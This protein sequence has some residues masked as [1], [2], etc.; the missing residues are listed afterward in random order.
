MSNSARSKV[1]AVQLGMF[2]KC[3]ASPPSVIDFS[4]GFQLNLSSG[5][6]SSVF[7]VLAI[8]CSN[9]GRI[10]SLIDIGTS[11]ERVAQIV[12]AR[13][14]KYPTQSSSSSLSFWYCITLKS[15]GLEFSF[16]I[17]AYSGD[18]ET[19]TRSE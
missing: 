12:R 9:S 10:I 18:G 14:Y 17:V 3:V 11:V 5:T 13:D 1:I 2:E 16:A 6:R 8:S 7:R 15:E 4:C 19:F